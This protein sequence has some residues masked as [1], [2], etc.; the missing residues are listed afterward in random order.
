M[1]CVNFYDDIANDYE[2]IT[3]QQTR[4]AAADAFCRRFVDLST[5][6]SVLDAGCGSGL[7]ALTFARMGLDVIGEDIS[8]SL[9]S[10]A[11]RQSTDEQLDVRWISCRFNEI[12][13]HITDGIDAVVCMGNSLVHV[14][15]DDEFTD[16]M[17]SFSKVINPA[18]LLAIQVLNYDR[19]IKQQER[20]VGVSRSGEK[21]FIR[22]YDYLDRLLRFNILTVDSGGGKLSTHL[23]STIHRPYRVDEL[24]EACKLAGFEEPELFG[25]LNMGPF[26]PSESASVI[27]LARKAKT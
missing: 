12:T 16:V 8:E 26:K 19:L 27:L 3:S 22:F 2:D 10:K 13:H 24:S 11:K 5:P 20:I 21:E 9:L 18:G 23:S 4:Q 15:D 7:Y 1:S 6:R 14:L 25:D 17:M